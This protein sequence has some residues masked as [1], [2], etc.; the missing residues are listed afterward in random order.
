MRAAFTLLPFPFQHSAM[1]SFGPRL[2]VNSSKFAEVR[3]RISPVAFCSLRRKTVVSVTV[4]LPCKVLRSS[5]FF[6]ICSYI[7][8]K[9]ESKVYDICFYCTKFASDLV[10]YQDP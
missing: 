3:A 7:S 10:Q 9:P 4:L 5:I 6:F 1:T 2:L 8:T